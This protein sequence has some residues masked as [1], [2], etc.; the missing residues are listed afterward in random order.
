MSVQWLVNDAPVL[1]GEPCINALTRTVLRSGLQSCMLVFA[2]MAD[3]ACALQFNTCP[4]VAMVD[5]TNEYPPYTILLATAPRH[6]D[7][8]P[9]KVAAILFSTS[10]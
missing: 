10:M 1:S 8:T 6:K 5:I 3:L 2:S 9:T 4:N 7:L